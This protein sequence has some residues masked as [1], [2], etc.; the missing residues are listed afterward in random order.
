M[1]YQLL[2]VSPTNLN[3]KHLYVSVFT[4][5]DSKSKTV[6][7]CMTPGLGT[8]L[9][10]MLGTSGARLSGAGHGGEYVM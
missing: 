10:S 8:R 1:E 2:E 6:W 5:V 7:K 4:M 9:K 3:L